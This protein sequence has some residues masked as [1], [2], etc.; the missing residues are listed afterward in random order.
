MRKPPAPKVRIGY[1]PFSNTENAYI[2][3]NKEILSRLGAVH[4]IPSL[5]QLFRH[6]HRYLASRL[7]VAII[8]WWEN[9]IVSRKTGKLHLP[10]LCKFMVKALALRLVARKVV[11]IRHNNYPHHTD[12]E[13]GER[14][15]RLLDRL[16]KL[17]SISVTHSGHNENRERPY[18]PHPLYNKKPGSGRSAPLERQGDYFVAFGRIQPYKKLEELI[19]GFP[20]EK[21]LII[22]GPCKDDEYLRRITAASGQNIEIRAGYLA[23]DEAERLVANSRGMILSHAESDMIVSG[24][25]FFATS[26]GVPVHAIKTPFFEWARRSFETRGLHIYENLAMLHDGIETAKQRNIKKEIIAYAGNSFGDRKVAE[27][28]SKVFDRIG[29]ATRGHI[30]V[31]S[32]TPNPAEHKPKPRH[33]KASVQGIAGNTR[34]RSHHKTK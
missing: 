27:H 2:D 18:V 28:W 3:R 23:K 32:S 24:S 13:K 20:P 26:I 22:A 34:Q 4:E 16:E 17:F 12:H 11:F 21:K 33:L 25:Y 31:V 15:A 8:N 7:D 30:Q 19:D 1:S 6:P 9:S 10:G 14:I 29:I 5:G